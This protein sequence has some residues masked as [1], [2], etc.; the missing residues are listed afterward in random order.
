MII[1]PQPKIWDLVYVLST[2]SVVKTIAPQI[3]GA[4]IMGVI[5]AVVHDYGRYMEYM[6][7]F[8][9]FGALTVAISLFLG[10]RNNACY[11]RWWEAR[12]Q[13]G[14]QVIVCRN[15]FRSILI[16][17]PKSVYS[18][19]IIN[20]VIAHVH[21]LRCAMR[22][23][24]DGMETISKFITEKEYIEIVEDP[25]KADALLRLAGIALRELWQN[26][27]NIDTILLNTLTENLEGLGSVQGSC[28]RLKNTP[29][30]YTYVLLVHRT[31]SLFFVLAPFALVNDLHW[32]TPL[33][34]G[35]LAYTFFALDEL[36]RLLENPF[37]ASPLGQPLN[38]ICRV[39]EVSAAGSL[40]EKAEP[41][42]KPDV[43][44]ILD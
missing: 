36:S 39:I 32:Y 31:L 43:N 41:L 21:A 22:G 20:Y 8:S 24:E 2:G 17:S 11:D 37:E 42:L 27:S 23:D 28:E 10:F 30:P 38:A 9:P 40:N 16:I 1:R 35:V 5:A 34:M 6:Y 3:L 18:K 13:L 44:G 19:R 7:D 15:L 26:D 25:N 33:F 4:M 29:L 14:T 12:K